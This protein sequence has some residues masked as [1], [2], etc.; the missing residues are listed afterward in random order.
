MFTSGS[1]ATVGIVTDIFSLLLVPSLYRLVIVGD[2]LRLLVG[3]GQALAG[4]SLLIAV[5]DCDIGFASMRVIGD[6]KYA[7]SS[8]LWVPTFCT[9]GI[10]SSRRYLGRF[11]PRLPLVQNFFRARLLIPK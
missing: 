1:G 6:S 7:S 3:L 9:T 8:S 10:E 4:L 11:L 2:G 5:K